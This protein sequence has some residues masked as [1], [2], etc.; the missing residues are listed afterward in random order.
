M[1]DSVEEAERAG[2]IASTVQYPEAKFGFS[3]ELIR[4]SVL[5]AL[6]APR[7]Q[8]LHLRAADAIEQVYSKTLE[9]RAN[10]LSFHLVNA[11]SA[12]AP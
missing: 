6:S 4:Q 1:L 10:D 7:R 12:A 3:H 9:D 5:A 2:L 8:R 11:G